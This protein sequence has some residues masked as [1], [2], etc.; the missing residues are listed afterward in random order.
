MRGESSEQHEAF[1]YVSLEERIP[2]DHP[3]R[4][5]RARAE[6]AL[7]R[8]SPVFKE[9]YARGGRPSI[10]PERLLKAQL[11]IALY[12]VRYSHH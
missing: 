11:L 5:I 4:T 10:P 2:Q 12:S 1:S 6:T 9:M 3:L 8:L 7:K